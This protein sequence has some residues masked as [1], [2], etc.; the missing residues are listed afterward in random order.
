MISDFIEK[1]AHCWNFGIKLFPISEIRGGRKA[2]TALRGLR[3]LGGEG[4]QHGYSGGKDK[5]LDH[6]NQS[7]D[8]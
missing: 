7:E 1:C 3:Q 2:V 4:R 8:L 6:Y 5:I